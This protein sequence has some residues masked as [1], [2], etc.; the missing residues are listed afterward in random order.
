M[1]LLFLLL[2]SVQFLLTFPVTAQTQSDKKGFSHDT[3][4]LGYI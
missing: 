2:L 4:L 1:H 3:K